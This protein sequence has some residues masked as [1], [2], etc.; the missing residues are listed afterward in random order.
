[1]AALSERAAGTVEVC[2]NA[3]GLIVGENRVGDGGRRAEQIPDSAAPA[4]E[5]LISGESRVADVE[6]S[7]LLTQD[8]AAASVD[9]GVARRG[10]G[11]G[12]GH[13]AGEGHVAEVEGD[14]ALV[15]DAAAAALDV[16]LDKPVRDRR[17]ASG[18]GP[19]ADS[20]PAGRFRFRFTTRTV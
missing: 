19:R 1:M 18:D 15:Q 12:D 2:Q 5:G 8:R 16:A 7:A 11:V 10:D 13:I 9:E 4:G 14:A 20:D 6:E 3:H 17:G